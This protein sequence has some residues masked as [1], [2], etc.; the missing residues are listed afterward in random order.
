VNCRRN[1]AASSPATSE[2]DI[3]ILNHFTI[4]RGFFPEFKHMM[5]GIRRQCKDF[6][7]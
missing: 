2:S 1:L 7:K 3:V 6:L 5:A 4:A